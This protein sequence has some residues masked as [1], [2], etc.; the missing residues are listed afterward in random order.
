[1]SVIPKLKTK[2]VGGSEFVSDTEVCMLIS[3]HVKNSMCRS[4][5]LLLCMCVGVQVC[6]EVS[7]WLHLR[8]Y[9]ENKHRLHHSL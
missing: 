8:V 5:Q 1:M 6:V 7:V 2:S 4:L 9:A 3:V